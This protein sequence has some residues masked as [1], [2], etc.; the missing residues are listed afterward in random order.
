MM[1]LA[2]QGTLATFESTYFNEFSSR[3][4]FGSID[5][6]RLDNKVSF[7]VA[8]ASR[9]VLSRDGSSESSESNDVLHD[10]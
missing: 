6:S 10:V 9:G 2:M 4:G 8:L 3:G 5:E 7:E 1:M